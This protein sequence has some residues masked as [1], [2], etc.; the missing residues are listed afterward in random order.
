[1]RPRAGNIE[2]RD[3]RDEY[4]FRPKEF[5]DFSYW[6]YFIET[7][8]VSGSKREGSSQWSYEYLPGSNRTAQRKL[9]E[10][11]HETLPQFIGQWFPKRNHD[12]VDD[13][14]CASMM[15]LFMPWRKLTDLRSGEST[16]VQA[17]D[18]FMASCPDEFKRIMDNIEYYYTSAEAAHRDHATVDL[19][20]APDINGDVD[21]SDETPSTFTATPLA[22][23]EISEEDL[24]DARRAIYT[25]ADERF[26]TRAMFFAYNA[27][28]FEDNT[29]DQ[30]NLP[31]PSRRA[32]LF[33]IEAYEDWRERISNYMR[34]DIVFDRRQPT[35]QS[36]DLPG[37]DL[38]QGILVAHEPSVTLTDP[39]LNPSRI[40]T[41]AA[42]PG[43]GVTLNVEQQRALNIFKNHVHQTLNAQAPAQLLM[44][45]NGCGGTGKS[46]L[47][48]AMTDTIEEFGVPQWLAKT[49]TSGVAATRI[50]G[51]TLHSWA[52]IGVTRKSS[53]ISQ[54][55]P[56][57]LA[58]RTH[59][60]APT[61]YLIVDEF[62][63][64]TK[65]LLETLSEV[66]EPGVN[67]VQ[68]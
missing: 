14:Y 45:V 35:A 63:M 49:A 15:A 28:I 39:S 6:D 32:S 9:R 4:I 68:D 10:D 52:G 55:S 64:L 13:M 8:E 61:Y 54:T 50:G 26:A 3:Q 37:V 60:I 30:D 27:G 53:A 51:M 7:Y 23:R 31:N 11:G 25:S 22:T 48:Q 47:I 56:K 65:S 24:D 41:T 38:D 21:D 20:P 29:Q 18:L 5:E 17:F 36:S 59:N 62:S 66:S 43:D 33:D 1:M 40:N 67:E 42:S 34:G 57:T 16:F 12:G 44:I 19:G 2:L 58:K 46:A